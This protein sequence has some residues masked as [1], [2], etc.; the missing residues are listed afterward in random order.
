MDI[1]SRRSRYVQSKV[2]YLYPKFEFNNC[3]MIS[4]FVVI[5]RPT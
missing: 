4:N 2:H 5:T 3:F 1:H